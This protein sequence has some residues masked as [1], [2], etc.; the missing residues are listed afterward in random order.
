MSTQITDRTSRVRNSPLYDWLKEEIKKIPPTM[1]I[2]QMKKFIISK[3]IGFRADR[4]NCITL[5]IITYVMMIR[6]Y[7]GRNPDA[8]T[9][10]LAT[11]YETRITR[12]GIAS[13]LD[14]LPERLIK[15]LYVISDSVKNKD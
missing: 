14:R 15:T 13:E 2:A 1:T 10:E 12:R 7:H 3:F 8:T 9:D 11:L 5:N 6:Y 4:E